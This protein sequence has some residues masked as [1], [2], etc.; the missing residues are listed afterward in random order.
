[1]DLFLHLKALV[2]ASLP[3]DRLAEINLLLIGERT[4]AGADGAPDQRSSDRST[5]QPAAD[6]TG[7]SADAAA[8]EGAIRC[9]GAARAQ[10]EER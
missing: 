5:E 3:P 7:A 4:S 9:A 1:M 6:S 2:P 10:R 8:T